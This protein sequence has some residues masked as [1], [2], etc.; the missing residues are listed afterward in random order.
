RGQTYVR[1]DQVVLTTGAGNDD[2]QVAQRDDGTLDVRVNDEN[3]AIRLGE[4]QELAIRS[5]AGNDDINVA[6]S[7]RVNIIVDGG[8]GND[9]IT[10]GAGNGR[11]DGGAGDDTIFGGAGRN[12]L[13][14][15]SGADDIQAG[16]D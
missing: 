1:F 4:N 8:A 5:G 9:R 6:A 7:V 15:N 14:G 13:S 16:D 3:Y 2:V 12:G 10:T 11:V